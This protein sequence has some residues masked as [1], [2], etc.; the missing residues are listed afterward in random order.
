MK[1]CYSEL[2]VRNASGA[3]FRGQLTFINVILPAAVPTVL[4][5]FCPSARNASTQRYPVDYSATNYRQVQN[6]ARSRPVYMKL[7]VEA[8]LIIYLFYVGSEL[9]LIDIRKRFRSSTCLVRYS[10]S[11]PAVVYEPANHHR[12]AAYTQHK[13]SFPIHGTRRKQK[14]TQCLITIEPS[15]VHASKAT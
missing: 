12:N 8:L 15:F 11:I 6:V 4:F 9:I 1:V 14:N 5:I 13:K 7:D 2:H 10:W 3:I